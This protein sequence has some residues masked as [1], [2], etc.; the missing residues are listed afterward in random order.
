M[1]MFQQGK[2]SKLGLLRRHAIWELLSLFYK[3]ITISSVQGKYELRMGR[4]EWIGRTLYCT[5]QYEMAWM[6]SALQLLRSMGDFSP[7]GRG[8]LLDVGANNGITTVSLLH[9]GEF[10]RSIAVEPDRDNFSLLTRNVRQN[11][12][13]DQVLCVQTALADK[14]GD[15]VLELSR[16]N[17]GDHRIRSPKWEPRRDDR[18]GEVA[19][20]LI[21]V[22]STTLDQLMSGVDPLYSE[23][24]ALLWL[25]V[26]GYEAFVLTGG[27]ELLARGLPSVLEVWPY[28]LQRAGTNVGE[29]C[30]IAARFWHRYWDLNEGTLIPHPITSLLSVFNRLGWDGAFSNILLTR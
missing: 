17:S 19:R 23:Q 18:Y 15:A 21:P 24:L 7:R 14:P 8:T 22:K 6:A 9:L 27:G 3:T 20:R 11:G 25:D 16:D 12:L 13:Q 30:S 2:T 10:E 4:N 5:G 29:F 26:Q 1:L 28:G